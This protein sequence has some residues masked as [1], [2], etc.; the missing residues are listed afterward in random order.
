ML[1]ID[2]REVCRSHRVS[3]RRIEINQERIPTWS[4]PRRWRRVV[5]FIIKRVM[6]IECSMDRRHRH[7]R[8]I[9]K[10]P[11]VRFRRPA[12]GPVGLDSLERLN[13]SV[14]VVLPIIK[15][16]LRSL[17]QQVQQLIQRSIDLNPY[18]CVPP[19]W[20]RRRRERILTPMNTLV[21]DRPQRTPSRFN[22][23]RWT[24]NV[25]QCF[26]LRFVHRWARVYSMIISIA[27]A[28]RIAIPWLSAFIH[29]RVSRSTTWQ[30]SCRSARSLPMTIRS[31][32]TIP[33]R[34]VRAMN[35]WQVE[36]RKGISH[37][38][39]RYSLAYSRSN[40]IC[41]PTILGF[42]HR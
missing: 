29:R 16:L 31:I 36:W 41:K 12:V 28:R 37:S 18:R 26:L 13:W 34:C 38:V 8:V 24:I 14:S 42:K 22:S 9:V 7:E 4:H 17:R 5:A 32:W 35:N 21:T 1:T 3:D 11:S 15:P 30:F 19:V 10:C 20:L 25:C 27:W 6:A 2:K 40:P 23:T 39:G 33:W